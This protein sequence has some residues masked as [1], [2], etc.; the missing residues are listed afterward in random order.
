MG[1]CHP[2]LSGG[3]WDKGIS[4]GTVPTISGLLT[5]IIS[6]TIVEFVLMGKDGE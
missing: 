1:I 3:T 5:T 4:S 6:I 2:R